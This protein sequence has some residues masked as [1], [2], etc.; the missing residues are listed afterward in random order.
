MMLTRA[1]LGERDWAKGFEATYRYREASVAKDDASMMG[2]H[3]RASIA[4]SIDPRS[5]ALAAIHYEQDAVMFAKL[6]FRG[7]RAYRILEG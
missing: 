4:A 2:S 6:A 1:A 3:C 7:W 5:T